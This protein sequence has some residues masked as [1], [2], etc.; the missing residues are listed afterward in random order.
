MENNQYGFDRI[1][2]FE[3]TKLDEK[4]NWLS[5]AAIWAGLTICVPALMVG[6]IIL[7]GLPLS[8]AIW[9]MVVGNILIL[10]FMVPLGMIAT[11]QGYP[12]VIN[13]SRVFGEKGSQS[14]I[15]LLITL[16]FVG[17]FSIQATVCASS[18]NLILLSYWNISFPMWVSI[19]IWGSIMLLTAMF[20]IKAIEK[21]NNIAVPL[22]LIGLIYGL[23]KA[24]QMPGAME[25]LRNHKPIVGQEITFLMGVNFTMAGIVSG[26]TTVGDYTRY[27]KSRKETMFSCVFGVLPA[28]IIILS[29]GGMLSAIS[30]NPDITVV[31]SSFGQP[32]VGLLILIVATW[33]TNS[34]TIYSAGLACLNLFNRKDE[35]RKI[36]TLILGIIAIA[37]G[38]IGV[39]DYFTQFLTFLSSLVPPVAGVAIADYWFINKGVPEK[40]APNKNFNFVGLASWLISVVISVIIGNRFIPAVNSVIISIIVYIIIYNIVEKRQVF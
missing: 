25:I 39:I 23:I 24:I 6:G 7:S 36:I 10:T 1:G 18:F 21:L 32:I 37:L 35:E 9:S 30:G 22:L 13:L 28:G 19:I 34:S 12:T 2:G 27:S 33:T 8:Q 5:I 31:L 40:W 20:G 14:T 16:T 11:D 3:R 17:W 38:I 29:I 15:S 26:A 4:K